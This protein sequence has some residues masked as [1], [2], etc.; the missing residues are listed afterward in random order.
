LNSTSNSLAPFVTKFNA[1]LQIQ[2]ARGGG[3]PATDLGTNVA[4]GPDGNVYATG[5]LSGAG[6]FDNQLILANGNGYVTE[7]SPAGLFITTAGSQPI[8]GLSAN[9]DRA[10]G[11]TVDPQ[12]LVD[13]TGGAFGQAVLP[14][15]NS[16]L[17]N[18]G[19][20][21]VFV[22]RFRLTYSPVVTVVANGLLQILGDDTANRIALTDDGHGTIQAVFDDDVPRIYHGIDRIEVQAAGGDDVVNH[23]IGDP[24][25]IGDPDP[26]TADLVIDLGTGNDLANVA[27]NNIQRMPKPERSTSEA[28]RATRTSASSTH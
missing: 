2:G 21:D 4:L 28:A 6:L 14:G 20:N 1:N 18:N 17:P 16:I 26:Q 3:G 5:L 15:Q 12:G 11:I 8:V 19:D 10:F 22:D 25:L 24:D 13:F 7:L 9:G 23:Q 27:F